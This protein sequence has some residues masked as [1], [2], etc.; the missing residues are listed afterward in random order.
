MNERLREGGRFNF[1]PTPKEEKCPM[2]KVDIIAG[3]QKAATS[4]ENKEGKVKGLLSYCL[5][6]VSIISPTYSVGHY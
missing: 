3:H 1:L 4:K 2:G 6:M 5:D